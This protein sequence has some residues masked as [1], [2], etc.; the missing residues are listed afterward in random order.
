MQFLLQY[1]EEGE[2]FLQWIVTGDETWM[3][4]YEPASKRQKHGVE[5]HVMAQDQEI[6]N[7]AFCWQSDV[8]TVLGLY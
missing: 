5:I 1:H 7:C 8:H 4:H 2:A 6:Q 3:H